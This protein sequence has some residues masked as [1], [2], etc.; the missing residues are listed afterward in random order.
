MTSLAREMGFF[1]VV[2]PETA[3]QLF[4]FPSM[5]EASI[6]TVPLLVNTDPLPALKIGLSSSSLT[7]AILV[8]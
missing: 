6:S 3:P 5:I 1:T 4:V 2:R 8:N 7:Y